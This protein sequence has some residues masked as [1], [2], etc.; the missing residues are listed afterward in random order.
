MFKVALD[1]VERCTVVSIPESEKSAPVDDQLLDYTRSVKGVLATN[2]RELRERAS[3][4]GIPVLLLRG[5][6][7]LELKGSVI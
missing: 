4:E 1:L 5:K 6:K 2:D 3:S 7:H